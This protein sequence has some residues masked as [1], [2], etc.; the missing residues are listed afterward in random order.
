MSTI[1]LSTFSFGPECS[2][3]R[4]IEFAVEHGFRG[5]ELGSYLQW[6]DRM[7]KAEVREVRTKAASYGID[8]SIHFIHRGVAPASHDLDRRAKHLGE[9]E[10][11]LNLAHDIGARPIV[12]H[13]GPIDCPGVEPARASE[14][15]RREAIENFVDFLSKGARIAEDTGTVICVE[16]LRHVPGYLV[17]SYS[18]L[19]ELI[20]QVDS[21]A[22]RITLDIGHADLSDGLRSAFETFAPYLRHVHIHDSDGNRDHQEVGKGNLDFAEYLDFLEPYAYT[23]AMETKDESD[24]EGCVLRSRDRLKEVL[25]HS[26]R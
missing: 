13:S 10:A 19:V 26:A 18:E 1:A 20:E 4:G 22:V 11:A 14:Q 16:N 23:L 21:E 3:Q 9:L 6:P 15:V 12:V 25:G 7:S 17:Q 24:A 5:L 2:A 8:L